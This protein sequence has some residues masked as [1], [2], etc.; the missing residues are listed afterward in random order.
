M[1]QFSVLTENLNNL[2]G[3]LASSIWNCGSV[4]Q[5][6]SLGHPC[7]L[8]RRQVNSTFCLTSCKTLVVHP[9]HTLGSCFVST[10]SANDVLPPQA[11]Y[12]GMVIYAP[13]LAL[14]QSK[15]FTNRMKSEQIQ[16]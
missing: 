15:T 16:K 11:L 8:F 4:D 9:S 13:A 7:T 14:N 10:Q 12:T 6:V 1:E 2:V 3:V 5:F